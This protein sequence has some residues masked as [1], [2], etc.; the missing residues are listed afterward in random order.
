MRTVVLRSQCP[1][2]GIVMGGSGLLQKVNLQWGLQTTIINRCPWPLAEVWVTWVT[3][4]VSSEK[5]GQ[6]KHSR[7]PWE[8]SL[9]SWPQKNLTLTFVG[10]SLRARH[11]QASEQGRHVRCWNFYCWG[12]RKGAVGATE[13][14][15]SSL[16]GSPW[17]Q[18]EPGFL[19]LNP[20]SSQTS[21]VNLG[22]LFNLT[23]PQFLLLVKLRVDNTLIGSL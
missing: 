8:R 7:K 16:W 18:V 4:F 15:S 19:G 3:V 10:V 9:F 12:Q 13:G 5:Y 2:R 6:G 17:W 11:C 14:Q 23:R 1:C 21:G 20:G 22:Q